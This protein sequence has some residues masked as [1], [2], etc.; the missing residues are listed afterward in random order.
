[1]D[2]L[3]QQSII[4]SGY[5]HRPLKLDQSRSFEQKNQAGSIL[6]ST[7]L[8][9]V[10]RESNSSWKHRNQGE[11]Q[12]N[13]Q[14]ELV[15]TAPLKMPNWPPGAPADGDYSN[16]GQVTAYCELAHMDLREYNR[17]SFE[18][19]VSCPGAVN[20]HIM[21]GLK[22]DGTIKIPDIYNREGYHTVNLDHDKWSRCFLEI[23][24]LPR[25]A[26]TEISFTSLMNGQDRAAV[27]EMT[28]RIRNIA[29]ETVEGTS[30]S[31]GWMPKSK[32]IIYSHNGYHIKGE[33]I[34]FMKMGEEAA[35][36]LI[37]AASGQ[38]VFAGQ[39]RTVHEPVGD[40][41]IFDFSQFK[42]SGR[43][44]LTAG[45]FSTETFP[46]GSYDRW[47][48][49]IWKCLNFIF[50]ERCGCPVPDKHGSCHED[51]TAVHDGKTLIFNGGW[52]DAGDVSQQLVQ[53]AEVTLNL[54]EAASKMKEKD[55]QL[56][57]R[58]MEE[59]E[60]GFDF[61]LKTRFGD[62]Y[63]ATSAGITIWSDGFI[64]DMDDMNARVH[65][66][67][68]ENFFCAG[69]Q[70]KIALLLPEN[71]RLKAKAMETAVQ[72][73]DFAVE[74]FKID[75]FHHEPVFWEHT[76]STSESLFLATI[77]WAASMLYKL[78]GENRYACDAADYLERLLNCQEMKGLMLD[79]G[80]YLKGFFYRD[81]TGKVIQHFNHQARE[82]LYAMALE[83][84]LSTQPEHADFLKWEAAMAAYGD[85]LE[86]LCRYTLPYPML[87]AG[88]YKDTEHLDTASFQK[89]H[90]LTGPEAEAD[91]LIQLKAGHPIGPGLYLKKFPVWFSFRGN[92]A[93][94]LSMGKS[95]S[96]I[97]SWFQ[98]QSLLEIAE[99]QLQWMTGMNPFGQSLVYGEGYEYAQQY[100]V[101][102][103]EMAG[104]IPVGIQTFANEDDPYWP[105]LNNAT[106]KEVWVGLAGKWMSILADLY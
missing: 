18:I 79:D 76:Y 60:W 38:A 44:Y 77:S 36:Q 43:Y 34:A 83:A 99:G 101:L 74:K 5:L 91:Y 11:V 87:P 93:I 66:N 15:L 98:K 39:G 70:A 69:I 6:K 81:S 30:I 27:G 9:T 2:Q 103:G 24:D 12:V 20:P 82:H 40:F 33:K 26:I 37:D 90:L 64:G 56:Y 63:R 8:L 88:V 86:Y 29:F 71:N 80:Q 17:I 92:N 1:M 22:N 78:T 51:I 58:L 73:Y 10:A 14:K 104:E 19:H 3:F 54:F 13:H 106:Y 75:G 102:T 21:V 105:Q 47:D 7:P 49:S 25:D 28:L 52:H 95:A 35:F 16:F 57:L 23:T 45:S 84:A 31:K 89:Q 4:E 67:A 46:I 55:L 41:T 62:G 72:D 94:L 61:M 48:A 53:T 50:C 59:A 97:G 68:Y 85:Y 42:K 65:N 100:S 32:S 96:I